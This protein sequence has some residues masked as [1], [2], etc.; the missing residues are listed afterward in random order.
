V[1]VC[2]VEVTVVVDIALNHSLKKLSN[3][4]RARYPLKSALCQNLDA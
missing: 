2:V 4:F 1:V 3:L